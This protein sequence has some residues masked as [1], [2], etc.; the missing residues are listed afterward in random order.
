MSVLSHSPAA[1]GGFAAVGPAGRAGDT[2]RSRRLPGAAAA[3]NA[4]SATFTA[5]GCG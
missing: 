3:A 1:R 4:S 2:D 5:E